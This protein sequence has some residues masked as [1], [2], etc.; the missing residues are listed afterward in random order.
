MTLTVEDV[1]ASMHVDVGYE[2]D[3]DA[4]VIGNGAPTHESLL[5]DLPAPG[6][7]S[8]LVFPAARGDAILAYE[9]TPVR[10]EL[11]DDDVPPCKRA[12]V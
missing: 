5:V 2:G 8:R 6:A 3:D 9:D 11:E 4:L 10:L 12:R 1:R 7:S